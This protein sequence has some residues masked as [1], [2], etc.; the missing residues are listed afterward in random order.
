MVAFRVGSIGL[1]ET[2]R[3]LRSSASGND[4]LVGGIGI[5]IGIGC[6]RRTDGEGSR[7]R[8]IAN[9]HHGTCG[10]TAAVA[11][12]LLL[13]CPLSIRPTTTGTSVGVGAGGIGGIGGDAGD[14]VAAK[15]AIGRDCSR[16]IG[17]K[18]R[19]RGIS[20]CGI[21]GDQQ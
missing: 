19:G 1:E 13:L 6:G 5:G 3:K 11:T 20:T 16:H 9:G 10:A 15:D 8:A 18:G 4:W 14:A 21:R 7:T 12:S 2:D 17:S